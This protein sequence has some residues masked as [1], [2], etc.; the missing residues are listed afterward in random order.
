MSPLDWWLVVT[1]LA[2][3]GL[4]LLAWSVKALDAG[5][6]AVAFL[7]G[8]WVALAGGILWLVLMTLFTVIGVLATAYGRRRKEAQGL[9]EE[10]DG[11]RSW[12]N[13]LA[14][15]SAAALAVLAFVLVDDHVAAALAF[16]TAVAAVTADTMASELGVLAPRARRIVPPFREQ[17]PGTNGAVSVQGQVA[18]AAG[19][20]A[21][22]L[23]AVWLIPIPLHLAWVPAV[24][25][26][27]GCQLDSLLGATLE[28]DALHDRPL[29]KQ[30]VNF[31]ASVLPA[32]A[33]LVM[34]AVA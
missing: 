5:G 2:L 22:A 25:G 26:F 6:A 1:L 10:V 27:A 15:G 29:S 33:V 9:V 3:T 8:L 28:R 20:V 16:T 11:E 14:N 23:A 32:L 12:R 34:F 19:A 7:L 4:A 18:A 21:I 30:D 17:V 24:A 13:V 31:L